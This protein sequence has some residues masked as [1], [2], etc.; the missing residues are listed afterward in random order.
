MA[1][2]ASSKNWAKVQASLRSSQMQAL[3][4]GQSCDAAKVGPMRRKSHQAMALKGRCTRQRTV[5]KITPHSTS[6]GREGA[7]PHPAAEGSKGR[8]HHKNSP[9]SSADDSGLLDWKNSRSVHSFDDVND[10]K[11]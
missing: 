5:S 10:T 3:R 11:R 8:E 9:K 2:P 7:S 1:P 6:N 4:N